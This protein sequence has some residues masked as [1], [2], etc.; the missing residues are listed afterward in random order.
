MGKGRRRGENKE[1][2]TLSRSVSDL[3]YKDAVIY[4]LD[5]KSF[6]DGNGDGIGDFIGLTSRL[7]Y[8]TGLGV[9]CL[10]L[11][12][13]YRSAAEVIGA[14]NPHVFAH[15]TDWGDDHPILPHNLSKDIAPVTL[16]ANPDT[17]WQVFGN[18][19]YEWQKPK[20][21]R[22]AAKQAQPAEQAQCALDGYGYVW[23]SV[24]Q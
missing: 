6:M 4:N 13:F 23:F 20:R 11:G 10:W 21:G 7:N 1:E 16:A 12:L 8:L 5:V 2:P 17:L 18:R 14:G 3:W 24:R 9:T 15:R 19:S 22:G